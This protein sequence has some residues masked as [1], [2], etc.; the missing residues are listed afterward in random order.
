MKN[1]FNVL[2]LALSIISFSA[3]GGSSDNTSSG[4]NGATT[5]VGLESP[6]QIS[7]VDAKE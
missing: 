3:C 7:T 5:I 1:Y 2:L 6:N 4:G